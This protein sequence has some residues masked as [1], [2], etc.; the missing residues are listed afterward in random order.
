MRIWSIGPVLALA[1]FVPIAASAGLLVE[2]EDDDPEAFAEIWF[3]INLDRPN[4]DFGIGGRPLRLSLSDFTSDGAPRDVF[5]QIASNGT[6]TLS[7]VED[8]WLP[9]EV[10]GADGQ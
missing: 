3:G 10:L 5:A 1:G 6:L 9:V 7:F 8:G 2:G 4:P